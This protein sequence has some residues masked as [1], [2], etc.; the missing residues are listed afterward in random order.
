MLGLYAAGL[1]GIGLAV[2]GL[3]RTVDRR[4][5]VAAI[6]ILTFVLDLVAPA[7]KWPDWV[8]QLALTS[9]MG[10]PMI[11]VWDWAGIVACVVLAVG[12]LALCGW[13]MPRRDV[14]R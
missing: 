5:D 13:G 6:V 7:L 14:E 12:G 1:A 3:F 9:H 4:R 2:G 11:G 8:H 10:Q